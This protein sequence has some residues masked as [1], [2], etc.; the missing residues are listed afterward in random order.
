M[1]TPTGIPVP[2]RA[3]AARETQVGLTIAQAKRWWAASWQRRRTW[4]RV[5]S[6]LRRVWSSTATRFCSEE[7]AWAEKAAASNA[8]MSGIRV[9]GTV[10]LFK[11]TPST[12]GRC[13]GY[14][15]SYRACGGFNG[16]GGMSPS[17]RRILCKVFISLRLYLYFQLKYCIEMGCR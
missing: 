7:R 4:S 14:F 6:G 8:V 15:L 2:V 12:L 9:L 11:K 5:A 17:L 13:A 1:T 16:T 10:M 3:V